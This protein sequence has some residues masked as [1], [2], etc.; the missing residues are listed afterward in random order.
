MEIV[1][2]LVSLSVVLA[3]VVVWWLHL[4]ERLAQMESRIAELAERL[5]AQS[6]FVADIYRKSQTAV[7][8]APVA[9]V[10]SEPTPRRVIAPPP[11][12]P[13]LPT[14]APPAPIE[15]P[16]AA[17]AAPR[18]WET[19]LGGNWLNKLGVFVLVVGLALLLRYSFTRLGPLGRVSISMAASLAMLAA[20]A[21]LESKARYRVFARG[22]LGSRPGR[23]PHGPFRG[24][25]QRSAACV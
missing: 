16:T 18:E 22:L 12:P 19:T 7:R 23:R 4:R 1:I 25:R 14:P 6:Q 11:P 5:D 21:I 17:P 24:R 2:V 10:V 8:P 15:L 3:V 9:P 20:G 13:P